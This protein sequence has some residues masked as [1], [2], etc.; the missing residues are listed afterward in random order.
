MI[1][2]VAALGLVG[3]S[4]SPDRSGLRRRAALLLGVGVLVLCLVPA[5]AG[6]RPPVPAPKPVR[7]AAP[8]QPL[9]VLYVGASITRGWFA[10]TSTEAYPFVLDRF[11]QTR[12][13]SVH[14]TVIAQPG[15]E[16]A[17]ALGWQ[18]PPA[19]D[20]VVVQVVTN[21]FLRSV[22]LASFQWSY[23]TLL[24]RIRATSPQ[25][26][27]VCMGAWSQP[28]QANALGSR[29]SDYDTAVRSSCDERGGVFVRL[30]Q[31]FIQPGARGPSGRQTPYGFADTF[32]P[33]D[34][35]QVLIAGE[36]L[37][38]LDR[39]PGARP[40]SPAQL[41]SSGTARPRSGG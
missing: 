18:L 27:L 30:A 23:T 35:G 3:R 19:Q 15:V 21:D 6:W 37:A 1:R 28:E 7:A 8:A 10:T 34:M 14:P 16:A 38:G 24:E 36:A 22:P 4:L 13:R 25:A 41:A 26:Q 31:L 33:N 20:V 5:D 2:L 11:L 12:G 32:H 39:E 40:S 29:T 17:Q 9:N